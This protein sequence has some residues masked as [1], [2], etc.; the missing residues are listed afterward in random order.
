MTKLVR[1]FKVQHCI[2]QGHDLYLRSILRCSS[3]RAEV[4]QVKH[5]LG[6]KLNQSEG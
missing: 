2:G 5:L 1:V 6:R 3:D 4:G